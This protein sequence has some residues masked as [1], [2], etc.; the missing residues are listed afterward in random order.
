[1]MDEVYH[2]LN[3]D[4]LKAHFPRNLR[5]ELIICRECLV[6]GPV[7]GETD[8]IFYQ[9]RARFIQEAYPGFTQAD[10]YEK[11]VAEL[12]KLKKIPKEASVHLWFEDDLFCQVNCWFVLDRLKVQGHK[13]PLFLVRPHTDLMFGFGTLSPAA[14]KEVFALGQRISP[15]DF[16]DFSEMWKGYV[17]KEGK[18]LRSLAAHMSATFPFLP[19][20]V[21]AEIARWV[22]EGEMGRPEKC[23]KSIIEELGTREFGPV[24]REFCKRE[25]IYGFGDLQVKRLMEKVK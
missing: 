10:Y 15:E 4:A 13:G 16:Q 22:P 5:G 3:G 20:A 24:F 9:N 19:E 1:M 25:S 23:L 17:L 7:G 18:K 21:E 11:T 6:D 8:G 14:L 12:E 2:I